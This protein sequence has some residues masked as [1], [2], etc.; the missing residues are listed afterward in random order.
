M[1]FSSSSTPNAYIPPASY[2]PPSSGHTVVPQPRS[3]PQQRK[4]P[5]YTRSKTGCLTCRVKKIKVCA[6]LP[7]RHRSHPSPVRRD[8]AHVYAL[9]SWS[10]RRKQSPLPFGTRLSPSPVHLARGRSHP[11]EGYPPE[12]DRR[13]PPFDSGVFWSLRD[14]HPSDS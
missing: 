12:R 7:L 1:P 3:E 11:E 8:K 13:W 9:H 6:L 10:T 14:V 4:R 2:Y 5:K